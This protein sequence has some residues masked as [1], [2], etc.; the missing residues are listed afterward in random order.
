LTENRPPPDDGGP[1]SVKAAAQLFVAELDTCIPNSSDEHHLSRV[2]RLRKGERVVASDGRGSWRSC[3]YTGSPP[4]LE[5]EGET[6]YV[7]PSSPRVTIGFTPVKGDRPEWV[8]Q[9]LVEVG[10]DRIVVLR[11]ERSV[12]V[13][14]GERGAHAVDRLSRIAA[15]AAAQ[16][17]RAWIPAVEGVATLAELASSVPVVLAQRGG[18]PL[19]LGPLLLV[20]PEGGW[21]DDELALASATVGLGTGVL[22]AETAA[23]VAGALVCA[24]RDRGTTPAAGI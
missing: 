11:A 8:V 9:K 15:Q 1:A 13:W 7:V 24:L 23:I 21:T 18:G 4:W 17:R 2:L 14:E 5:P 16:S 19:E 3:R 12:V 10:V 6:G 20:G 22:R